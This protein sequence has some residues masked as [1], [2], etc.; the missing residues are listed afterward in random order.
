MLD[1]QVSVPSV[2]NRRYHATLPA[3]HGGSSVFAPHPPIAAQARVREWGAIGCSFRVG[4]F[5]EGETAFRLVPPADAP[6]LPART[7]LRQVALSLSRDPQPWH[8]PGAR[9]HSHPLLSL[10]AS[11]SGLTDTQTDRLQTTLAWQAVTGEVLVHCAD[12]LMDRT[13][14][15]TP[16]L[17]GLPQQTGPR[18]SLFLECPVAHTQCGSSHCGHFVSESNLHCSWRLMGK[19]ACGGPSGQTDFTRRPPSPARSPLGCTRGEP[20][21]GCALPPGSQHFIPLLG[22]ALAPKDSPLARTSLL[23]Q[24]QGVPFN[25][26]TCHW[27]PLQPDSQPEAPVCLG[28]RGVCLGQGPLAI[29]VGAGR[30]RTFTGFLPSEGLR[31]QTGCQGLTSPSPPAGGVRPEGRRG[32]PALGPAPGSQRPACTDSRGRR[33]ARAGGAARLGALVGAV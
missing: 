2:T 23:A 14:P 20:L 12:P 7:L 8:G 27:H 1:S 26:V 28:N 31:H 24:L 33:A 5:G 10:A 4:R 13:P 11:F 29:S 9:G 15:P 3:S 30:E 17:G 25:R 19:D 21:A 18:V 16:P 32:Q 22:E 6:P